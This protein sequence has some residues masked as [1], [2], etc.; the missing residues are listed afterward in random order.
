M[1]KGK[2]LIIWFKSGATGKFE[3]VENFESK[4]NENGEGAI[5]FSYFG[6]STQVKR[7]AVFLLSNI[8]GF[9]LE[10]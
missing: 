5:C 6:V 9:A 2:S 3:R 1:E 10:E 4:I 7:E 8:A